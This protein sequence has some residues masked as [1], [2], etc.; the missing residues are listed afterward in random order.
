MSESTKIC[1]K[2]NTENPVEANFCRHCRYEFPEATKNGCSIDPVIKSLYVRESE[3]CEGSKIHIEWE[4]ENVTSLDFMGI[5]V[6]GDSSFEYR[7]GKIKNLVLL[8]KNDYTQVSKTLH[9]TPKLRG[10]ILSFNSSKSDVLKGESVVLKWNVENAKRVVLKYND[11]ENDVTGK[12]KVTLKISASTT[13]ILVAYSVDEAIVDERSVEVKVHEKVEIESF[14]VS[15]SYIVESQPVTLSWKVKNANE[16]KLLPT[17]QIVTNRDKIVL[18]P[19]IFTEYTLVATNAVSTKEAYA[20][21]NVRVLPK[22]DVKMV[23][24]LSSI[25][26]PDLNIDLSLSLGTFEDTNIDKWLMSSGELEPVKNLW[27]NRVMKKL[28]TLLEKK[29]NGKKK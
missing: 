22:C 4:V 26:L 3:Y 12:N 24:S 13:I 15:E 21:V 9:L 27:E 20:T 16:I 28:K 6:M 23:D 8:A 11:E 2:C 17:H 10:R 18:Y 14:N 25:N 29:V 7:V 19:K 5:D 1:P